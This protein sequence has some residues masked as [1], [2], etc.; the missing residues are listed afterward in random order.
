M[1]EVFV[2]ISLHSLTI[3][4]FCNGCQNGDENIADES[5]ILFLYIR[6]KLGYFSTERT[7]VVLLYI[8]YVK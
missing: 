8:V 7:M 5:I 1:L 6:V 3:E 2:I 4:Y